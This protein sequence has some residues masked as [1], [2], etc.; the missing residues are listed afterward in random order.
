[1]GGA[2]VESGYARIYIREALCLLSYPPKA[3]GQG[4]EPRLPRSERGVLPVRRSRN[5]SADV[6]LGLEPNDVVHA[7]RLPF[8][9]GSP[10]TACPP[11]L[12][13]PTWRSFGA[14]ILA[15]HEEIGRLKQTLIS[16]A[17]FHAE[18]RGVFLSQAGPRFRFSASQAEHHSFSL[19]SGRPLA[20][21]KATHWVALELAGY[22]A[23]ELARTPP[24]EGLD[25]A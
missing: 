21:R 6:S 7:T 5:A 4:L 13:R 18:R 25:V 19:L 12:R 16:P 1:M 23:R 24:D 17:Q 2:G 20:K 14:R 11:V 3:P 22:A 10:P 15:V 8:D 9:P